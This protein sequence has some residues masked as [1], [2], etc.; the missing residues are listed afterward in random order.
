LAP[1]TAIIT[2]ERA[3]AGF[4]KTAKVAFAQACAT[5]DALNKRLFFH[6]RKLIKAGLKK[7]W[8]HFTWHH[9]FW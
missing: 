6:E 2:H 3:L 5:A 9:F 8:H 1:F 7:S 4:P